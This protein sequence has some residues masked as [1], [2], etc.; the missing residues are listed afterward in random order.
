[1]NLE[2][3]ENILNS[4][5]GSTK[6]YPFGDDVAV[7]KVINKMFALVLWRE[8]PLK[9]NLKCLPTDAKIYREI[10]KCVKPGYHMNKKHWN[11]ITID[12]TIKDEIVIDMINE[13]YHLVVCKL[14]K[15]EKN[16]LQHHI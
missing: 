1:M 14:T 5:K 13:S 11:T 16:D 10:Y 8:L 7:F 3:L 6:E 2:Q 12:D 4:K 9:I 15:K